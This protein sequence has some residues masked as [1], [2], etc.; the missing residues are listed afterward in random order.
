M[1]YADLSTVPVTG[2]CV[3]ANHLIRVGGGG[4]DA[5]TAYIQKALINADG[6]LGAW[7]NIG[8]LP[9]AV[10]GA[11]ASVNEQ[12][13]L[14]I[15]GGV[16]LTSGAGGSIAL[17]QK[18]WKCQLNGLADIV[19]PIVAQPALPVS[20]VNA[21]IDV[22]GGYVYV[23]GGQTAQ[24][25]VAF[26]GQPGAFTVGNTV[27][28]RTSGASAEIIAD[29]DGGAT[30]TLSLLVED[31]GNPPAFVND[32][33][34]YETADY[35]RAVANGAPSDIKINY[36]GQVTNFTVGTTVGVWDGTPQDIN[37]LLLTGTVDAD[38]DGGATG[39]L[40][41]TNVWGTNAEPLDELNIN[42]RT[43]VAVANGA[44]YRALDYDGQ[45]TNFVVNDYIGV[46]VGGTAF[47]DLD[48]TAQIAA[49]SDAGA[50]GTLTLT[51]ITTAGALNNGAIHVR[52]GVALFIDKVYQTLAYDGG[53]GDFTVGQVVTGGTSG[54]FGTIAAVDGTTASGTLTLTD[55]TG[56]FQNNEALTDPIT[57]AANADGVL[58]A[59]FADF[60][61]GTQ[62]FTNG[63][64][65]YGTTSGAKA[66][67]DAVA[68]TD[69][70]TLT[71]SSITGTFQN[72]EVLNAYSAAAYADVNGE[73][74]YRLNYDGQTEN[75]VLGATLFGQTSGATAT[76]DADNDGGAT[77][78][79]SLSSILG[80]FVNNE[81][82]IAWDPNENAFVEGEPYVTLDYDGQTGNFVA[83]ETVTGLTSGATLVVIAGTDTGAAGT[84]R[85]TVGSGE[86]Q[87][88]E[89]LAGSLLGSA[90]ADGVSVVQ[91][92]VSNTVYR[93]RINADGT[94][95]NWVSVGSA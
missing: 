74:V 46:F 42:V 48:L 67:I 78:A 10:S 29:V 76:I 43:G 44:V 95:G 32:E 35:G 39:T 49:D 4:A 34:V 58:S 68:G 91:G 94:L 61:S 26:D 82:I 13:L 23:S 92:Q 27:A 86:F 15:V 7:F 16:D 90:L 56:A 14:Y 30:G 31:V 77:G 60:Y 41:L 64:T 47:A 54:A 28:G 83:G 38:V 71:I 25:E 19:S 53:T 51:G 18:V 3:Y 62:N 81:I 88:N 66:T 1:A 22:A 36:D 17:G 6:S 2:T 57:G 37:D 8:Q 59:I 87:N 24:M 73:L 75:F 45:V 21:D 9:S 70:G 5:G 93:A 33:T 89:K 12:G 80:T 72:D 20:L 69:S 79:L 52:Q 50:T 55:I 65:L 40:T 11:S 85:G 84:L 63:A